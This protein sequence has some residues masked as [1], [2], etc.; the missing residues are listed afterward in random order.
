MITASHKISCLQEAAL[1][2]P[3]YA[4]IIPLFIEI[5]HY[6]DLAGGDTGIFFPVPGEYQQEQRE[7]GFPLLPHDGLSVDVATCTVFLKGALYVLAQASREGSEKLEKIGQALDGGTLPLRVL[8]KSILERDRAT[9][10]AVATAIGVPTSLLEYVS[11]IPLKAA[12][13]RFTAAL[14][15]EL[16]DGWQEG[17]C[18]ICGSRA[19]MAELSGEEGKRY[20]SC[21][22]CSF[23]WPFKRL[24]CPYC[25]NDNV[26]KLSYFTAGEGAT[27]VDTCTACSRYIKTRDS[28]KGNSGVPLDVEDLLTMHLDLLAAR[29]GFERG[30]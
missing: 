15:P 10:D 27:R 11:E 28:R 5:Y 19:G 2:T 25:G 30:K 20:L 21:S 22:A 4:A 14:P 8:F 17:Y 12:L 13:E 29:E 9:M 24:Q 1:K 18:P 6:L 26:E 23:S 16:C 7:N 3:E